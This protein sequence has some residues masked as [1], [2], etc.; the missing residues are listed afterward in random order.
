MH[1]LFFIWHVLKLIKTY[2][3]RIIGGYFGGFTPTENEHF[4]SEWAK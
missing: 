4:I 2:V 1:S 3:N